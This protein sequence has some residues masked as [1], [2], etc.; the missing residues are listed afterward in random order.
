[1]DTPN[2]RHKSLRGSRVL[3][4]FQGFH[5]IQVPLCKHCGAGAASKWGEGLW[6]NLTSWAMCELRIPECS[7]TCWPY[8]AM[9]QPWNSKQYSMTSL[10]LTWTHKVF[11]VFYNYFLGRQYTFC[12]VLLIFTNIYPASDK[13]YSRFE[14]SGTVTILLLTFQW[15]SDG[16]QIQRY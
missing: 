9:A 12:H 5:P 13:H 2:I 7:F 11:H 6:T 14:I 3:K 15:W 8:M 10:W 16:K 1:M 4:E